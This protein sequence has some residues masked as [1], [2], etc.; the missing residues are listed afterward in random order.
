[1]DRW[2]HLARRKGIG[3][4]SPQAG[5]ARRLTTDQRQHC[6]PDATFGADSAALLKRQGSCTEQITD[7]VPSKGL[8]PKKLRGGRRRRRDAA[9]RIRLIAGKAPQ[10]IDP[11]PPPLQECLERTQLA[12]IK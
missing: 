11:P 4:N 5:C 6:H 10:A 7:I 12:A 8:T 1:M 3:V 9:A 2:H